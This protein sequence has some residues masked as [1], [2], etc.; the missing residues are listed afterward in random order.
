M[1]TNVN[2]TLHGNTNNILNNTKQTSRE[3]HKTQ[4]NTKTQH[5]HI[6]KRMANNINKTIHKHICK[7]LNHTHKHKHVARL[8]Q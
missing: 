1:I 8:E 4:T 7:K 5:E 6:N 3:S 2:K